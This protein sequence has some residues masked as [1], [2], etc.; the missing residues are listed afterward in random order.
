MCRAGYLTDYNHSCCLL[1]KPRDG[2]HDVATN[3]LH[4]R[5]SRRGT[6]EPASLPTPC[7]CVMPQCGLT[8]VSDLTLIDKV[9]PGIWRGRQARATFYLRAW[10]S[11]AGDS[12]DLIPPCSSVNRSA[13]PQPSRILVPRLVRT[14]R[15]RTKD[16]PS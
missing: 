9:T 12:D 3:N 4:G 14:S 10:H 5:R 2:S 13:R 1:R 7:E 6:Q 16:S 8:C 11:R 15:P